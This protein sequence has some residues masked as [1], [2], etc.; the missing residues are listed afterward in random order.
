MV[1]RDNRDK[2]ICEI[3]CFLN[4]K[5]DSFTFDKAI[6]DIDAKTKDE[7]IRF[8]ITILWFYYD[9]LRSHKVAVDKEGWDMIQRLLLILNSD[10][11][12]V[13]KKERKYTIRQPIALIALSLFV[14][15]YFYVGY[16]TMLLYVTIGLGVVSMLLSRWR[17]YANRTTVKKELYPFSDTAQLLKLRRSVASF[18]KER[19]KQQLK[20][21]KIRSSFESAVL[22]LPSRLFWLVFSPIVLLYQSFPE[23]N[24]FV[25][26]KSP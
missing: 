3:Q 6:F 13:E 23:T 16:S 8:V 7:T 25:E 22:H 20:K 1:D 14:L 10:Q 5:T 21:R 9:D 19:Y 15:A 18:Q 12:I 26:I 2:L 17:T 24:I 11:E 4:E